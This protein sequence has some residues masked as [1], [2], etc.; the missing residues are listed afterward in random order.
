M[1]VRVV[2]IAQIKNEGRSIKRFLETSSTFADAIILLDQQSTDDTR[3][4]AAVF[5]KVKVFDNTEKHLNEANTISKL[6]QLARSEAP[7]PKVIIRLDADEALTANATASPEWKTILSSSPGTVICI[8]RVELFSFSECYVH[9]VIDRGYVDDGREF[10]VASIHA[11]STPIDHRTPTLTC[12]QI[13]MLHYSGIRKRLGEAKMRYYCMLDN[14]YETRPAFER[15]KLY[16]Q[17]HILDIIRR[18]AQRVEFDRDWIG[19]YERD[20]ID[21]TSIVDD[22]FTWHDE[23]CVDLMIEH[24]AARFATDPIW[25]H[26]WEG[27][28]RTLSAEKQA[29]ARKQFHRPGRLMAKATSLMERIYHHRRAPARLRAVMNSATKA[30]SC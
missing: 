14:I 28:I 5:P 15:R 29:L 13:K 1:S 3:E 12:H 4:I 7:G 17:G 11:K 10:K 8:P 9:S 18:S 25:Y 27:V 20:G 30:S 22:H 6:Y 2:V 24:G 16:S 19:G 21:M 26:D 23:A